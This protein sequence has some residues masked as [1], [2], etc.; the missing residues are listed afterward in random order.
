MS[1]IV[2]IN[3]F[4]LQREINFSYG[5]P[6]ELQIHSEVAKDVINAEVIG[7]ETRKTSVNERV[8]KQNYFFS[9]MCTMGP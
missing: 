4:L 9:I 1:P 8:A 3:G 5:F 2:D 6:Q 7:H